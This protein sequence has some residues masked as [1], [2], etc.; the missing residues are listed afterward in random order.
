[1]LAGKRHSA[2]RAASGRSDESGLGGVQVSRGKAD[3]RFHPRQ[4]QLFASFAHVRVHGAETDVELTGN[5]LGPRALRQ[6]FQALTLSIGEPLDIGWQAHAQDA[7]RI[8][9]RIEG[10]EPAAKPVAGLVD[11]FQ[12]LR[13]ALGDHSAKC[14]LNGLLGCG[15]KVRPDGI[16]KLEPDLLV[17]FPGA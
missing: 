5:L 12:P 13:F 10:P 14:R 7:D 8:L 17:A 2:V 11:H 4:P 6:Q 3:E 15:R 1:M 9:W 16:A